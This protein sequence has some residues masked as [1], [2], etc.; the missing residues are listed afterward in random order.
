MAKNITMLYSGP[1][2]KI[3]I[4][5]S[6]GTGWYD[7]GYGENAK[8]SYEPQSFGMTDGQLYASVGL[9]KCEAS[10]RQSDSGSIINSA[11]LLRTNEGFI[12]VTAVTG[13]I[14][15]CGPALSVMTV[16]RTFGSADSGIVKLTM[17]KYIANESDFVTIV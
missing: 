2:N 8:I 3:E 16:D 11:S 14:Y 4:S 7:V 1:V 9:G 13:K 6:A 12:K 10:W 15:T 5:G 17:Q